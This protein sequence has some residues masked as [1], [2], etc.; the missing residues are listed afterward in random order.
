MFHYFKGFGFFIGIPPP[1]GSKENPKKMKN[2][3]P[4]RG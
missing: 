2:G 4:Q 1:P 3:T